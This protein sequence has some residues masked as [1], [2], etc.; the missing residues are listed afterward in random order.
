MT[1]NVDGNFFALMQVAVTQGRGLA[2]T[3]T[4]DAPRVAVI[5]QMLADRFWPGRSPIGQRFRAGAQGPWVEIVGVIPTGRYFT[6]AEAPLAFMYL[7][8]A[9]A[10]RSQMT[11]VVSSRGDP[12]ALVEPLRAA[13]RELDPDLAVA[14]VRTMASRYYDSAVRNFMVFMY[15]ISAMGVMSLT[16]AFVGLYGLV[17][18]NVSRRTREIGI[19]MAVGADRGRVLKMVLG[20]ALRVTVIG[21]GLGLALT[22]GANQA[23][24]AAFPGGSSG[25]ER[26]LGVWLLVLAVMLAV[27]GLAA[28]LPAR[29]AARIEPTRALRYE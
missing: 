27:T 11:L 20:Q 14:S 25:S 22:L 16:L 1:S 29:R 8:Y 24:R 18:S 5:N 9:Q 15:A 4:A 12:L 6:I 10:P 23:M 19:R 17:A 3:D 2:S 21:L 26:G 7:P 28:Y 13:V